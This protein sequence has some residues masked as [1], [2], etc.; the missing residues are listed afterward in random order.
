MCTYMYDVHTRI[1]RYTHQDALLCHE[2]NA[3]S[4]AT[5]L[6]VAADSLTTACSAQAL[7]RFKNTCVYFD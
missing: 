6:P 7:V 3:L 1:T 5:T 2:E 4:L